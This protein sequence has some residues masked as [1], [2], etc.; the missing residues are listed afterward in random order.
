MAIVPTAKAVQQITAELRAASA[1]VMALNMATAQ[2]RRLITATPDGQEPTTEY[3]EDLLRATL[4]RID[5]A[6]AAFEEVAG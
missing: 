5:T 6:V 3:L 2:A 4:A 1:L